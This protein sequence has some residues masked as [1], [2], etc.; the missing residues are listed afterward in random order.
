MPK[1]SEAEIRNRLID[2]PGWE[3][4]PAGIRKT[5]SRA[6]FMAGVRIL[7]ARARADRLQ[8]V[9]DLS[10]DGRADWTADRRQRHLDAD[11]VAGDLQ[12]VDQ[13]EI[14]DVDR[15]F[16]VKDRAQHL[17]DLFARQ[18]VGVRRLIHHGLL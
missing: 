7:N 8:F 9:L 2:L 13:P 11:V 16:R 10:G 12:V 14:P 1:L 5:Y 15:N 18:R 17:H 4:T 3:L 6:D